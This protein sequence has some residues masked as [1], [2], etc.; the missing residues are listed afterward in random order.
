MCGGGR[1][2]GVFL[3]RLVC[4]AAEAQSTSALGVEPGGDKATGCASPLTSS[5]GGSGLVAESH[6]TVRSVWTPVTQ[7]G[8][9]GAEV[10]VVVVSV[11]AWQPD[12][13]EGGTAR[14]LLSSVVG[15]MS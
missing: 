3:F 2:R 11:V 12:W 7:V 10:A 13:V 9:R 15:P 1:R 14:T 5:G 6:V 4:V 8:G